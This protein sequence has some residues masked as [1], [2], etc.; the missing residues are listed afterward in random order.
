MDV[1]DCLWMFLEVCG[2]FW[3]FVDVRRCLEG[4]WMFVDVLGVYLMFLDVGGWLW[5]FLCVFGCDL[6]CF[7][8]FLNSWWILVEV[9]EVCGSLFTFLHVC[10]GFCKFLF[11]FCD[12]L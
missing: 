12:V 1:F 10:G 6:Y 7:L 3:R 8:M 9:L 2:Y 11:F 4:L 5:M